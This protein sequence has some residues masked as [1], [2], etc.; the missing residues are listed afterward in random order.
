MFLSSVMLTAGLT[1]LLITMV[2]AESAVD[3]P[4][5]CQ[6]TAQAAL[7]SCR[8]AAQSDYCVAP[9]KGENLAEPAARESGRDRAAGGQNDAGQTGAAQH[10]GRVAGWHR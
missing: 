8:A 9:G 4:N 2:T 5:F 1:I 10:D 7:T 6:Q 3:Q